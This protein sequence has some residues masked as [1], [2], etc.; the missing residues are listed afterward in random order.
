MRTLSGPASSWG[1]DSGFDARDLQKRPSEEQRLGDP[2][3]SDEAG[4]VAKEASP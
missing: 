1:T 3:R 2:S 4:E